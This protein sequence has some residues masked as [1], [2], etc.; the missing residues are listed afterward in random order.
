MFFSCSGLSC[1]IFLTYKVS[2][3]VFHR[4]SKNMFAEMRASSDALQ[5]MIS[6]TWKTELKETLGTIAT[7][8]FFCLISHHFPKF[9]LVYSFMHTFPKDPFTQSLFSSFVYHYS[10]VNKHNTYKKRQTSSWES[11]EHPHT[12]D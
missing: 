7:N 8:S 9:S 10:L 12:V 4:Y 3:A 5:M 2:I 6:A 1:Y 11:Y